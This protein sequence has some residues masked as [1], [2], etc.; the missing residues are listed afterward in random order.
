MKSRFKRLNSW[1]NTERGERLIS[2]LKPQ[3]ATILPE[4]FGFHLVQLGVEQQ[5]SLL[6]SSLINHHHFAT[7]FYS[8]NQNNIQTK[9]H[10]LPFGDKSV[11]L[12]FAPFTLELIRERQPLLCELDRIT[13]S[14]GHLLFLGI[15]PF[16]FW[17]YP[18]Y[19]MQ[20]H[21]FGLGR[22]SLYNASKLRRNLL[23]MGFRTLYT[24]RFF[25]SPPCAKKNVT[26][27][28]FEHLGQ[29]ILP[30]PASFYLLVAQKTEMVAIRPVWSYGNL[31]VGRHSAVGG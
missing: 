11:D 9:L 13:R 30:F 23:N 25:Y 12:V 18:G 10:E 4:L 19:L 29:M 6:H 1:F 14:G 20:R 16:G 2:R 22:V 26:E 7:P 5:T 31:V 17:G 3:L 15:N 24:Q 27:N 28:M 8:E 21:H